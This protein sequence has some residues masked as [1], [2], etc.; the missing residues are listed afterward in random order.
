MSVCG[1]RRRRAL[2]RS[3]AAMPIASLKLPRAVI[4]IKRITL[5]AFVTDCNAMT[6]DMCAHARTQSSR[7]LFTFGKRP[8]PTF[9][10]QFLLSPS[11]I[12][13]SVLRLLLCTYLWPGHIFRNV[14]EARADHF[15]S[16]IACHQSARNNRNALL[17]Q[18][19]AKPVRTFP[20]T[21]NY[22]SAEN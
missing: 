15:S 1:P 11:P 7:P 16:R 6:N 21:A 3:I 17:R 10:S 5:F 18:Q 9:T 22:H 2:F 13:Q 19:T 8:A 12:G 20:A 4:H 14:K